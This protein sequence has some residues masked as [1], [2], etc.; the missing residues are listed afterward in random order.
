[1]EKL[2]DVLGDSIDLCMNLYF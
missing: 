2:F 1:M